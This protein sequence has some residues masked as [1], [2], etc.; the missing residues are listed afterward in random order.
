[1]KKID[2]FVMY[3][4]TNPEWYTIDDDGIVTLTEKATLE[5]IESLKKYVETFG[6][7]HQI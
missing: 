4:E 7:Q 3:W 2:D 5:A 1:M 6:N